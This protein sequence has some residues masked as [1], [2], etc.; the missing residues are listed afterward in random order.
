MDDTLRANPKKRTY[1]YCGVLILVL[2]DDTLRVDFLSLTEEDVKVLILVLMDDTLRVQRL[3]SISTLD[4]CL[5]P[6]FN[7]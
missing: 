3:E 6:C 4:N 7:G 5:N 2:M 1:R